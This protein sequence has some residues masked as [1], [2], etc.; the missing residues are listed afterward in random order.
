[1]DLSAD[2]SSTMEF[3]AAVR[4]AAA[5]NYHPDTPLATSALGVFLA[6]HPNR[7][8]TDRPRNDMTLRSRLSWGLVIIAVCLIAP[9]ALAIQSLRGLHRDAQILNNRDFAASLLIARLREGLSEVRRQELAL[10]FKP[11]AASRDAMHRGL[12]H[13]KAMSD[14]LST[15]SLGIYAKNIGVSVQELASAA[16]QEFAATLAART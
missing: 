11:D 4:S 8:C 9:L 10:L 2:G 16:E 15:F 13:A 3:R 1:M 12:T 14:T 6:I 5:R 7:N